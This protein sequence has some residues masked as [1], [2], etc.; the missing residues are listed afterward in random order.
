MYPKTFDGP[1]RA[2]NMETLRILEHSL[3]DRMEAGDATARLSHQVVVA[4]LTELDEPPA[5][6]LNFF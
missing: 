6:A 2:E 5:A 4:F 1:W 3:K